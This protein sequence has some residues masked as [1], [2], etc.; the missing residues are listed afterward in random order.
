MDPNSVPNRCSANELGGN[1]L[2][3]IRDSMAPRFNW[4]V[5]RSK[6]SITTVLVLV[7]LYTR[8]LLHFFSSFSS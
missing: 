6:R 5:P 8:G 4:L 3:F 7:R 2:N 1:D